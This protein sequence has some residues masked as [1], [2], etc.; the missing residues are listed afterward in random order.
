VGRSERSLADELGDPEYA[1][2]MSWNDL[3]E[4]AV[5]LMRERDLALKALGFDSYEAAREHIV[6]RLRG[7]S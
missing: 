7:E 4:V 5:R 6:K 2:W 3:E 1:Q